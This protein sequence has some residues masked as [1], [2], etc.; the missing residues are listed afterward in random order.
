[1]SVQ[2]PPRQDNQPPVTF[3]ELQNKG[4]N[5][6]TSIRSDEISLLQLFIEEAPCSGVVL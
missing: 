3:V 4:L 2:V 6:D 1:M 5:M